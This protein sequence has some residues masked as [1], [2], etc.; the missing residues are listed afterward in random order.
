LA[1]VALFSW[2]AVCVVLF[3]LLPLE[4]AAIWSLLG[5]YLLLPSGATFDVA[6][7]P[8][9]DKF[10]IP[11]LSTILL[12]WMKGTQSPSPPRSGLIY[13][14]A[15]VFVLSPL[16]TSLD[17]SYEL[18]VGDHSIPGF[19]P[20]DAA[21]MALHNLITLAPFFV[22][23]RFLSS[24]K[25]RALLL[26]SMLI[27]ALLYSIPMLFEI[28][29][30]PQLHRLVYGFTSTSFGQT[31]RAGGYRPVVFLFTGLEV[32][33]FTSMAFI[34]AIVAVRA[35]WRAVNV[36]AGAVATFLGV[37]LVLCKTM[38]A[39]IYAAVAAPLVLFTRPR[40]WVSVTCA[41]LLIV[42]AYP[43]LRTAGI[44]PV[45]RIAE[46][47][48]TISPERS[49]SFLTRVDNEDKLLAKA[50]LKPMFGWGTWGRNRIYDKESGGDV[51]ITDGE[52]IILFSAF[53]WLGYLSMFGLFATAVVRARSAVRGP[54]TQSMIIL[55]GLCLLFGMNILDLI[56][57]ANLTPFTFLIAGS[58]G[59][60]VSARAIRRSTAATRR[61]SEMVAAGR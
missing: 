33:L 22:G 15:V 55:A 51:T 37:M 27:A 8:P 5:G 18:Q 24:D 59:G 3:L 16:F 61:S 52:W 9:L 31:V 7:L 53:G 30:S 35:K 2:P 56:P 21:K 25:A 57:N 32:A 17:N 60:C 47:A 48:N 1:F 20:L 44:V 39:L 50:N 46:L 10:T 41:I 4:T 14:F 36:P 42:C 11:A 13:C 54:P 29:F 45:H 6:L 58:I 40:T 26:K 49:S 12:C 23:M 19:Y 43:A 38:G 34:G 28:R